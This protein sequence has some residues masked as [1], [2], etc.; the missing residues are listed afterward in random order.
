MSHS[1][2]PTPAPPAPRTLTPWL[3]LALAV[4]QALSPGILALSGS[5]ALSSSGQ[6]PAITPA[7]YAFA[8][9]GLICALSLGLSIWFVAGGRARNPLAAALSRPRCV[10]FAGFSIWLALASLGWTWG[11]AVVLATMLVGRVRALTFAVGHKGDIAEGC[12]TGRALLWA[13]L[14]AYTGWTSVAVWVN[15]AAALAQSGAP[16]ARSAATLWQ[17]AVLA[18]A[19]ATVVLVI[20]RAAGLWACA[21]GC[22]WALVA[23]AVGAAQQQAPVLAAAAGAAV[24]LTLAWTVR[25]RATATGA[26]AVP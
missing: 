7:G 17:L 19:A 13:T 21:A 1:S 20:S 9:W 2:P 6:E 16:L 23:A 3:A 12:T 10:V 5:D 14:G 11:T 22:V 18:G 4:A 8:I 15:L 24:V 25:V 26:A